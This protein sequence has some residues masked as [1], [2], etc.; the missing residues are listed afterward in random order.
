MKIGYIR[1]RPRDKKLPFV[2]WL[3]MLFQGEWPWKESSSSHRALAYFDD[4]SKE[5]AVIHSNGSEGVNEDDFHEFEKHYTFVSWIP[6]DIKIKNGVFA[7]WRLNILGREYDHW[8]IAG[9]AMKLLGLISF[10]K[11]GSNFKKMTCNEVF[12]SFC[13]QVLKHDVGDPDN[14]D[15]KMTDSLAERVAAGGLAQ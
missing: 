15:M 4:V 10:N 11:F 3:I 13:S 2:A 1:C 14:W 12:L 8:Q 7:L 5:W 6:M 9:L